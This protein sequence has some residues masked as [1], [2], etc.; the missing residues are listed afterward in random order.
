MDIKHKQDKALQGESL[1]RSRCWCLQKAKLKLCKRE[2][3]FFN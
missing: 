3:L 1:A 2:R